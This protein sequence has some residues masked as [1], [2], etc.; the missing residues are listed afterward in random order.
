MLGARNRNLLSVHEGTPHHAYLLDLLSAPS[1]YGHVIALLARRGFAIDAS[2]LDRDPANTHEATASVEAAWLAIYQDTEQY[3]D[4]YD[5][6]EKLVD[7]EFRFQQWRF[8]H[9]KTV[10]R[11]IGFKP[12]TGGT[13]GVSYLVKALDGR[14]FPELIAVRSGI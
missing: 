10:E 2:Q 12:G 14:F 1:L 7:L 9:M 6:A 8:A 5:L 3:W 11:I 4:L 13:G